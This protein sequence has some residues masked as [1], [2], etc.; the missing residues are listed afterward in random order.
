MERIAREGQE[1]V[2]EDNRGHELVRVSLG[3]DGRGMTALLIDTSGYDGKNGTWAT[4]S[5]H[6]EGEHGGTFLCVY[7]NGTPLY[8]G[9]ESSDGLV[10]L[11]F[12][13]DRYRRPDDDLPDDDEER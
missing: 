11:E 9:D 7:L 1:V 2:I 13:P 8:L 4:V 6:T 5:G 10:R 12:D 3:A